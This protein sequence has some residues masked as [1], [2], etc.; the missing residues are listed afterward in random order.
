MIPRWS[1][2]LASDRSLQLLP[3]VLGAALLAG[4]AM[5][6]TLMAPRQIAIDIPSTIG[7][8]PGAAPQESVATARPASPVARPAPVL[9][10]ESVPSD[11]PLSSAAPSSAET[12]LGVRRTFP[13][14][15]AWT[16]RLPREIE[17]G[18]GA[19]NITIRSKQTTAISSL[20]ANIL[21]SLKRIHP[22][23]AQRVKTALGNPSS[24]KASQV[25][26]RLGLAA[27]AAAPKAGLAGRGLGG[28]AP[29]RASLGGPAPLA[30][31]YAPSIGGVFAGVH[32]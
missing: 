15:D 32:H 7:T 27:I 2:P 23:A 9:P 14:T 26:T 12:A 21:Q 28:A 22:T 18:G 8:P 13:S 29:P 30:A 31:R 3:F 16:A 11:F 24:I 4:M 10:S 20:V 17:G 5:Q 19:G 6:A 1:V 25:H